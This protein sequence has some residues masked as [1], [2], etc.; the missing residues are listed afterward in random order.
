MASAGG[1]AGISRRTTKRENSN[2]EE[3]LVHAVV[4]WASV[5]E[6]SLL[7]LGEDLPRASSASKLKLDE[8]KK[9][10]PQT[11]FA[12]RGSRGRNIGYLK[13]KVQKDC[14]PLYKIMGIIIFSIT[15]IFRSRGPPLLHA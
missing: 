5:S 4:E 15:C 6:P 8:L 1:R 11:A 13:A 14:V 9:E 2:R 3:N 12:F 10:V 7:L